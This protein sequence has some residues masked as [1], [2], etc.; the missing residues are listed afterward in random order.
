[1]DNAH[2]ADSYICMHSTHSRTYDFMYLLAKLFLSAFSSAIALHFAV[3]TYG[4]R[5]YDPD[6]LRINVTPFYNTKCDSIYDNYHDN[7]FANTHLRISQSI[8][9]GDAFDNEE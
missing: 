5:N 4:K 1:M 7:K 6:H 9:V 3:Q 2:K 8:F